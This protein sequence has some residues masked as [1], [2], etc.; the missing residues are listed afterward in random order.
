[1]AQEST[2][3]GQKLRENQFL[4]LKCHFQQENHPHCE[5]SNECYN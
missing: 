2:E 1:M 5:R 3:F 4:A